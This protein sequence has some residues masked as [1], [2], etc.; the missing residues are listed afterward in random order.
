MEL[1]TEQPEIIEKKRYLSI[2]V[3]RGIAIVGMVFVNTI[4]EFD[5][6]PWW[7]KHAIDFGLTYADLI[8]PFFIFA[9]S[10][11]YTL[12][13]R[14][15]IKKDGYI[16][17]YIKFIRRYAALLGFGFLGSIVITP[18]GIHFGWAVLQ[19]IG[20]AGIF[21]SFFILIPKYFRLALSF[22][23]L[24]V[25]Q[26]VLSLV[27]NIDGVL[28]S[29]SDLAYLS[30]HG[31]F[32]GG[33]GWGIMLLLCT[34]IID[35]FRE[36]KILEILIAG[37]IFSILG[38]GLDILWVY[39]G[40]PTYGGISKIRVTQSYILISIGIAML[41]FCLIWFIYDK[42]Q[43]TKNKSDFLG[44]YGKNALLLFILHPIFIGFSMLYMNDET[45]A[46]L[47][48]L[49]ALLN[50]L[51]LWGIAWWLDKKEIYIII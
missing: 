41:L 16:Q 49:S 48:A 9:I 43:W 42:K 46:I 1:T 24:F 35:D 8:A 44:P 34:S 17:T 30:D 5:T 47:V 39:T 28:I 22:A 31:G 18:E 45:H 29:I 37:G 36:R 12:S 51:I 15:S 11:T 27:V 4:A 7:S 40:F 19:A 2:D 38:V 26:F 14:S 23:F 3:F 33:F 21:T 50:V 32:I 13:F 6:V 10:L 25:Y 20:L